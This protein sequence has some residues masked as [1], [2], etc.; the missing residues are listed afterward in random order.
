MSF[1]K[2]L[3][4]IPTMKIGRAYQKFGCC[5]TGPKDAYEMELNTQHSARQGLFIGTFGRSI[6]NKFSARIGKGLMKL[7]CHSLLGRLAERRGWVLGSERKNWL[8]PEP[9]TTM[10][11]RYSPCW[12]LNPRAFKA[13][14]RKRVWDTARPCQGLKLWENFSHKGS[15]D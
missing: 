15:I 3:H 10:T 9:L 13:R 4:G 5:W 7:L 6:Y 8:K 1:S 11:I 14:R 2:T 12:R